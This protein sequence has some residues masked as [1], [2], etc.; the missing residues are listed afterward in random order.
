[1]LAPALKLVNAPGLMIWVVRSGKVKMTCVCKL[2][3]LVLR[4]ATTV[5][6]S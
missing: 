1:M 2:M 5:E 3:V 4:F 6:K